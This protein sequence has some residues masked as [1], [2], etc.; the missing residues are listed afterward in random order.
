MF[1]TFA[2]AIM[3]LPLIRTYGLTAGCVALLGA[4]LVRL[5]ASYHI[6]RRITADEYVA[7]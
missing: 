5:A 2:V 7:A 1:G 3:A 6:Q 4:N